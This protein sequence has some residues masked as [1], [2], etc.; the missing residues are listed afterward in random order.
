MIERFNLRTGDILL[1]LG[2]GKGLHASLLASEGLQVCGIEPSRDGIKGAIDRR[3]DAIF[4]C[5]GA[6]ELS[7]YFDKQYFDMIFCRGMSW[8]HRELDQWGWSGNLV[9]PAPS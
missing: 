6:S 2:C 8:F 5:A 1:D 9:S 3:S 4:I 7:K